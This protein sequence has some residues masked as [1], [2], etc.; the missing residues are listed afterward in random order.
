M[1]YVVEQLREAEEPAA[2][3]WNDRATVELKAESGL[4]WFLHAR[5]AAEW[6]LTLCF[7]VK[8]DTFT[9]EGLDA[10]LGLKPLDEMKEIPVYGREPRVKAR[11]LKTAWQEVTIKVWKR[12][13]VATPSFRKFLSDAW[14][15]Y[16]KQSH[17]ESAN[18]DDLMPWKKLGRKW[19]LLR[20]GLPGNGR[21]PWEFGLL[22]TLLPQMESGLQSFTVDYQIRTKINWTRE[23]SGRLI[24]ELQTKR[25]DG[26]DLCVYC[27]PG[28]VTIGSIAA[29]GESQEISAERGADC[30]RIRFTTETQSKS[31]DVVTFLRDVLP[32]LAE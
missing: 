1:A 10:T 17:V 19:H 14:K 16:L 23:S 13:E 26:V 29:L 27:R 9:T 8:K 20:K 24:A 30:V 6:L 4:G 7:R 25:S 18:P 22:E 12:E 15:S 3:N 2:V 21:I 31:R 11:N 32:K 5:T 28:E